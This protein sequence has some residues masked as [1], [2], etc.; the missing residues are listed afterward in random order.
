MEKA[1]T[2]LWTEPPDPLLEAV[3]G[4]VNTDSPTWQ[5]TAT[6]LVDALGVDMKPNTLT[7]RLNVTAGRLFNERGVRYKNTRSHAGRQIILRYEP[8]EA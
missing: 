1:E 3:A 7:M 6:A 8:S 4:I 5:G 2:E